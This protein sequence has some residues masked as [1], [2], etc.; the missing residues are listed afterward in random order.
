MHPFI[1]LANRSEYAYC[2]DPVGTAAA[3]ERNLNTCLA[4]EACPV[5]WKS[6]KQVIS[7]DS[8]SATVAESV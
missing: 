5:S 7:T 4:L 3:T 8:A 6:G 2:P 1:R